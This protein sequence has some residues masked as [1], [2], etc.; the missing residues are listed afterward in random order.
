MGSEMCIRDRKN[1][2]LAYKLITQGTIE[3]K[4]LKLQEVKK[5]LFDNIITTDGSAAKSLTEEDINFIL[6]A[7]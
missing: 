3:E 6:G 7:E 1:T 4:I 2:V 5:E